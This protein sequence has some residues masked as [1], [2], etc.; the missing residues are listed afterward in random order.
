MKIQ[1]E[2]VYILRMELPITNFGFYFSAYQM[3]SQFSMYPIVV[4]GQG[5]SVFPA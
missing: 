1:M 4:R 5:V 3:L 2:H